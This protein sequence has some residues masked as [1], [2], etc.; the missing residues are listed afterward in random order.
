MI[1]VAVLQ[2]CSLIKTKRGKQEVKRKIDENGKTGVRFVYVFISSR[3]FR[4]H[5]EVASESC[6][7]LGLL[8]CSKLYQHMQSPAPKW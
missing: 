6:F 8:F 3:S 5:I 7:Q 4:I 1:Q 2:N